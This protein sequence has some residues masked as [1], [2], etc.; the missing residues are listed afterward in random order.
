MAETAPSGEE[1]GDL[2]RDWQVLVG[3]GVAASGLFLSSVDRRWQRRQALEEARS[4]PHAPDT[5]LGVGK[6]S[7]ERFGV[8]QRLPKDIP[9]SET[10]WP[11]PLLVIKDALTLAGVRVMCRAGVM[12]VFVSWWL[13]YGPELF[14]RTQKD[15]FSAPSIHAQMLSF[16]RLL[17]VLVPL[18]AL[19]LAAY[20]YMRLE[21]F[22]Q[23]VANM[24]LCRQYLCSLALLVAGV[25]PEG[26]DQEPGDTEMDHIL[27]VEVQHAKWMLFRCLNVVH[28]MAYAAC[29]KRFSYIRTSDL[30]KAGFLVRDEARWL[31][32]VPE[33]LPAAIQWAAQLS[34][35]LVRNELAE[36]DAAAPITEALRAVRTACEALHSETFCS[37]PLS[38]AHL[39]LL[40]VDMTVA[41]TP[42]ALAA[43]FAQSPKSGLGVYIWPLLGTLLITGVFHGT[44]GL[45]MALEDPFDSRFSDTDP[46]RV[47]LTTENE[48]EAILTG[49]QMKLPPLP[50][51]AALME[52]DARD[53]A[54]LGQADLQGGASGGLGSHS[55]Q[56]GSGEG[57]GEL[58]H[59]AF[60]EGVEGADVTFDVGVTPEEPIPDHVSVSSVVSIPDDS[61]G[62]V[63]YVPPL[64]DPAHNLLTGKPVE[65]Q[66][67]QE[68]ED[69]TEGPFY[70]SGL[71]DAEADRLLQ[72]LHSLVPHARPVPLSEETMDHLSRILSRQMLQVKELIADRFSEAALVKGPKPPLIPVVENQ[73]VIADLRRRIRDEALETTMLNEQL[74]AA[75]NGG[76]NE[77][78]AMGVLFPSR[79]PEES[80]LTP[81]RRS[82][83]LKILF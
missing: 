76:I 58:E 67:R 39:L 25:L 60:L 29:C 9:G 40:M 1:D 68:P 55:T 59:G 27:P 69:P 37:A 48:L 54:D 22:H 53:L 73:Q 35:G 65:Q 77:D 49:Q 13:R 78:E 74:L 4:K 82:D 50:D 66:L 5:F 52:Q 79:K 17:E 41:F 75:Q 56:R 34:I 51:T 57:D 71:E 3:L 18:T 31:N 47:L 83:L 28:F 7:F 72:V 44:L 36:H 12:S 19:S 64:G 16:W 2:L 15:F 38:F 46:D 14:A 42:P 24:Q 21:R 63:P 33:Q 62:T 20:L 80:A 6:R 23:L 11:G 43:G 32:G 81:R 30:L 8:T 26:Q 10:L 70:G 45:I 61:S